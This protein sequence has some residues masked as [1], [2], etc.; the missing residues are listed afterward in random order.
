MLAGSAAFAQLDLGKL[1]QDARE[2]LDKASAKLEAAT[3][4]PRAETPTA[5][6]AEQV[7][8]ALKEAL[9]V[10]TGNVVTQLSRPGIFKS[11]PRFAIPLPKELKTLSKRLI[12]M[13]MKK[14]VDAFVASLNSG[15]EAAMPAG[16]QIFLDALHEMTLEDAM[17]IMQGK[18]DEAT[19]YFEKHTGARLGNVFVPKVNAALDTVGS[20]QRYK[21]LA[22]AYNSLPLV[23]KVEVDLG[24]YVTGRAL[25]AMFIVLGEEEAK[26]RKEAGAR[27]TPLLKTV[28]GFFSP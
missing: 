11:T 20:T 22:G 23:K 25:T 12:Q 16:K 4:E 19:R 24:A 26:V 17:A 7:G 18:D 6:T 15:A 8:K 9:A 1:Q 3:G 14:D 5:P 27:V 21:K 28:F 2:K 10:G 13:G